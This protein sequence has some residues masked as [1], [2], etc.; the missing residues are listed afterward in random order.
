MNS[1]KCT[2]RPIRAQIKGFDPIPFFIIK[3]VQGTPQL[4]GGVSLLESER[5]NTHC[6]VNQEES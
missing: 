5:E 6:L 2:W 3:T 4:A 1:M